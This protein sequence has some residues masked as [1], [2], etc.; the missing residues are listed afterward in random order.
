MLAHGCSWSEIAPRILTA[1]DGLENVD[2]PGSLAS[3]WIGYGIPD[4][5]KVLACTAQRATI[6]GFGQLG[7]SQAHVYKMPLPPSLG[8]RRDWRK[9]TVTLAWLSPTQP[10]TQKYRTASMWF[11][12]NNS[13]AN[14]RQEAAGGRSG[15]QAVRRGTL[16][17]EVFEG[18][19]AH[20]FIDGDNLII[21][22]NCRKEAAEI[23]TM[24]PY[25][26]IVSLEVREGVELPIYQEVR[27]R[28]RIQPPIQVPQNIA[29]N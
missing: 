16:Q 5:G 26:V 7:D 23:D 11:E 22:I 14:D 20:P 19:N 15:W 12:A 25:G 27:D 9:L 6:I 1:L 29:G 8:S 28:V 17:H 13:L 2:Q 3:R 21:K 4:I 10:N 24:I 18:E